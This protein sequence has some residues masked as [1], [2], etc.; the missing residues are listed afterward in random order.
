M[1]RHVAIKD[2]TEWRDTDTEVAG[3]AW[4]MWY[5]RIG[6]LVLEFLDWL[7]DAVANLIARL[8]G[9]RV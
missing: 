5:L 7:A 1:R 2:G 8:R 3:E 6:E 4:R 9:K